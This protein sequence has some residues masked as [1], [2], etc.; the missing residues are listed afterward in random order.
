MLF[1]LKSFTTIS[2]SK[3]ESQYILMESTE[4]SESES[5]EKLT[6]ETVEYEDFSNRTIYIFFHNFCDS[7]TYSFSNIQLPFF[8]SQGIEFP[9]ES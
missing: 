9:P 2:F 5:N 8:Y 1:F 7:N 3:I 6:E 4:E